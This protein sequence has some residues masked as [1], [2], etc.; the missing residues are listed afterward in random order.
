M[1]MD[2]SYGCFDECPEYKDEQPTICLPF[3]FIVEIVE[4]LL[5][6]L[7][8]LLLESA[9]IEAEEFLVK[10]TNCVLIIRHRVECWA[11]SWVRGLTVENARLRLDKADLRLSQALAFL[12]ARLSTTICPARYSVPHPA[13]RRAAQGQGAGTRT[14]I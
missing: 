6:R 1:F 5:H 9:W 4:C 12:P 13:P 14:A 2:N 10:D 7:A 11:A 3:P 8:K